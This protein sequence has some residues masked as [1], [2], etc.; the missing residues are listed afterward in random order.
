[1]HAFHQ[2]SSQPGVFAGTPADWAHFHIGVIGV[3][4]AHLIM[5]TC[6]E[7]VKGAIPERHFLQPCRDERFVVVAHVE[8][9]GMLEAAVRRIDPWL[10]VLYATSKSQPSGLSNGGKYSGRC[11]ACLRPPV[12]SFTAASNEGASEASM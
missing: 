10:Q 4:V 11:M 5:H 3:C 9:V 7:A 1:M 8:R 12:T 2:L 6:G